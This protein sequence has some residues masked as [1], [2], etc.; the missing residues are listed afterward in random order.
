MS[1]VHGKQGQQFARPAAPSQNQSQWGQSSQG[2]G[3]RV[4]QGG[5][6]PAPPQ[7]PGYQ[8]AGYAPQNSS[9]GQQGYGQPSAHAPQAA[10]NAAYQQ[11]YGG[12]YGEPDYPA[13]SATP[14]TGGRPAA[15]SYAPQFEP[16]APAMA[17][18]A[19]Q[20][21]PQAQRGVHNTQ[22]PNSQGYPPQGYDFAP[23]T[24]G[25]AA[26][27][28]IEPQLSQAYGQPANPAWG[29]PQQAD[30]RSFDLGTYSPSHQP[31]YG[32]HE[33]SYPQEALYA[34]DPQ[35]AHE[36]HFG[37]EQQYAPQQANE[38]AD[39][40]GYG[41][42][43]GGGYAAE[44]YD[45]GYGQPNADYANPQSGADLGFAQPAGG[46]LDQSYVDEEEDYEEEAPSRARRP[47]MMAAVL[48]GAI[49]FGGGMT[50][51]YKAL[52][53]G[54][55]A[56]DPPVIKSA[57]EPSKFK[58]ADGGGKQFA[59]TDSKIMGRLGDGSTSAAAAE[60]SGDTGGDID[61][62]GTR[63]VSTL[64]VGR[65]GSIQAPAPEESASAAAPSAAVNVPGLTIVDGLGTARQA[66]V[67]RTINAPPPAQ[68]PVTVAKVAPPAPEP[69][70]SIEP[71]AAAE[72]AP[73][74]TVKK[75]TTTRPAP[76]AGS[77]SVA[78]TGSGFVAV[79]ASVPR[80]S[81]SRM[82]ALKRFADMQQKYASVLSG[83][84]PDVAEANLGAKGS[85]HRLVVGPPGSREQASAVCSQLK[86]QGYTDCWVTTY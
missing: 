41:A 79:L 33:T 23:Q 2:A 8:N 48:V 34:Q 54:S 60:T 43:H 80:S 39:N 67:P 78:T 65:D 47:M 52:L 1:P 35:Y 68:K 72:P 28:H 51:G 6:L 77:T 40:A 84:T 71:E 4:P 14:T 62:N 16:L 44:G 42:E 7:S 66:T 30:P 49:L 32:G 86:T 21:A 73:K 83:K 15:Q 29:A 75:T 61:A 31:A 37:A 3:G 81:S 38:W 9:Y 12:G 50:Y 5:Q 59:H 13:F 63:K 36:P 18:R 85:Y 19:Q 57:A 24:Q 11:P 17:P 25:R 64:V 27:P 53:G 10:N 82:D 76:T 46:E 70:G 56:G 45:Q 26:A 74:P 69:T 58:P 55:S 22:V 20:P